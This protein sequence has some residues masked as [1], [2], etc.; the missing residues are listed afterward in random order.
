MHQQPVKENNVCVRACTKFAP[1]NPPRSQGR[2]PDPIHSKPVAPQCPGLVDASASLSHQAKSDD[3]SLLDVP[4]T[5]DQ[6]LWS[7]ECSCIAKCMG[8]EGYK[9]SNAH[10]LGQQGH[11]PCTD[12]GAYMHDTSK[13]PEHTL[14][15]DSS[16]ANKLAI[17]IS[18]LTS[19]INDY[20]ETIQQSRESDLECLSDLSTWSNLLHSDAHVPHVET[21]RV[22][23]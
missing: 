7:L 16:D 17:S 19:A 22:E 4:H 8:Q 3:A 13:S 6:P 9:A 1:N 18:R 20:C 10:K 23:C 15:V 5:P 14:R 21:Q 2:P 11:E 12:L